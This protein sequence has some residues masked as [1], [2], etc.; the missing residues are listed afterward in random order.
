MKYIGEF[1]LCSVIMLSFVACS[2][3]DTMYKEKVRLLNVEEEIEVQREH[4]EHDVTSTIN[5][6]I[7]DTSFSVTLEENETSEAFMKQLESESISIAMQE[8]GGFEKVGTIE[9]ELPRND[10][11]IT[12]KAGDLVLYNGKQI[13]LFYGSNT[14]SYTKIGSIDLI[15]GLVEAVGKGDIV[16]TFTSSFEK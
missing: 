9:F 2:K 12:T 8:Y 4:Q 13:V 3:E 14:W 6:I 16:V 5:L 15:D 11:Q 7:G 10:H 1:I